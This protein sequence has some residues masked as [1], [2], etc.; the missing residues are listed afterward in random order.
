MPTIFCDAAEAAPEACLVHNM[1][2]VADMSL[3]WEARWTGMQLRPC[4]PNLTDAHTSQQGKTAKE[5][6]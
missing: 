3:I 1:I 4:P 5:I 6:P 2:P